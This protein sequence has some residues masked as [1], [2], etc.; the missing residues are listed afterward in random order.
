M[1]MYGIEAPSRHTLADRQPPARYLVLIDSGEGRIACLYLSSH[2]Q[3]AEF[4][5]GAE[6]V[7]QMIGGLLP[8]GSA[9]GPEW[10]K[11]L[12]GFSAADRHAA[13]VYLLDV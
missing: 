10:D 12:A 5:A 13:E 6:E 3:V 4:D 2:L 7:A 1:S 11:A 8:A 9:D